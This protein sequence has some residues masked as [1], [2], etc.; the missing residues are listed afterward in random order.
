MVIWYTPRV[1]FG[2]PAAI[3]LVSL[4]L[5]FLHFISII[6]SVV[7]C[8]FFYFYSFFLVVRLVCRDLIIPLVC[9]LSSGCLASILVLTTKPGQDLKHERLGTTDKGD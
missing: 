5:L 2:F 9:S 3:C 8:S 4:I 6:V 7:S 1:G